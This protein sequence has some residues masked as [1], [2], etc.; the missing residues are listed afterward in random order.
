MAVRSYRPEAVHAVHLDLWRLH[1]RWMALW[2]SRRRPVDGSAAR[3]ALPATASGRFAYAGWVVLGAVA[4]TVLYPLVVFGFGLRPCV[5]WFE[6]AAAGFGVGFT[7]VGGRTATVLFSYPAVMGTIYLVVAAGSLVV[8]GSGF[9][10]GVLGVE[11]TQGL[12]V[13]A[14]LAI[15]AGWTGG[16]AVALA[17][18]VRPARREQI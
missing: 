3:T 2:F 18:L 14:W 17:D 4:V 6:R 12:A 5:R 1:E 16:C 10:T 11:V 7:R 9:T 8:P 15:P 13:A